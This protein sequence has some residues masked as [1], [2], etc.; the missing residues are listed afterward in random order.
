MVKKSQD[1]NI[2]WT[3][4]AKSYDLMCELL[5]NHYWQIPEL[6]GNILRENEINSQFAELGS[7]T[8]NIVISIGKSMQR[9]SEVTSI[10]LNPEFCRHQR[11]KLN[12]TGLERQ[13][14]LIEGNMLEAETYL[15]RDSQ[16]A[17]IMVHALNFLPP[18]ERDQALKSV[19]KTLQK[20]GLFIISDIGRPIQIPEWQK[21][22]EANIEA[23]Y[24]RER[25]DI[26]KRLETALNANLFARG[27]Q[28]SGSTYMHNLV[29]FVR[30]IERFGFKVEVARD[31]LY[32]RIDDFVIAKK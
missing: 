15:G 9:I 10:E 22:V 16:R 2:N 7:G 4:Y 25:E 1:G 19:Y 18:D 3:E 6:I 5:G 29:E 20:G 21:V 30:Y 32:R 23:N 26:W 12:T 31:D 28:D 8:G 17:L 13:I 11:R 14:N 24:P 27:L